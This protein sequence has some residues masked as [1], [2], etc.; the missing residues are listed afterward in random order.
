[1]RR[2]TSCTLPPPEKELT[3]PV[4]NIALAVLLATIA[5][6]AIAQRTIVGPTETTTTT[7]TILRVDPETRFMTVRR[8]D[9]SE[10]AIAIPPDFKRIDELRSGEIITI[11]YRE[12]IVYRLARRG[13]KPKASEEVAASQNT[14]TPPSG[15][16]SY[17]QNERVT[18][19]AVD[20]EHASIT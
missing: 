12:S 16:L 5:T 4:G 7:V 9:G 3:H 13:S 1:T 8:E 11:T 6:P 15:T 17:Q 10:V 20:S 14:S 2:F 18:V 19:T